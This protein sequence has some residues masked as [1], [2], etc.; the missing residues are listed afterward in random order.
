M[1]ISGFSLPLT[2]G[3]DPIEQHL[4]V[5]LARL[6][7]RGGGSRGKVRSRDSPGSALGCGGNRKLSLPA[8][9]MIRN[10]RRSW[11]NRVLGAR[12]KP[13]SWAVFLVAN[14]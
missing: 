2:P 11:W 5:G 10:G 13:R 4:P 1:N 12:G 14:F 9:L 7:S 3:D 6:P 8:V